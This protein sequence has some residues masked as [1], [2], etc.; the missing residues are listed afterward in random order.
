MIETKNKFLIGGTFLG[1]VRNND[2][3]PYDDDIDIGI[4]VEKEEDINDIKTKLINISS[5]TSYEYKEIF[6][7][8]KLIKNK[9]GI[10]IFIYKPDNKGKYVFISKQAR[11]LWSNNYYYTHELNNL[12]KSNIL[13]N[14]YN[15]CSNALNVLKRHYGNNWKTNYITHL[16][17]IDIN[18]FNLSN[19]TLENITNIYLLYILKIF[20][21]NKIY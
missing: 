7:G 11:F 4:Y 15:I 10:D 8:C 21:M 1:S 16:H 2:I 20:K 9:I 14:S 19:I 13:E 17:S 5:K 3:I 6:F 12:K 18:N